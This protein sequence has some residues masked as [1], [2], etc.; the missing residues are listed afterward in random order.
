[1]FL[2][3]IHSPT[4]QKVAMMSWSSDSGTGEELQPELLTPVGHSSMADTYGYWSSLPHAAPS[5]G[6]PYPQ[7]DPSDPNAPPYGT[8]EGLPDPAYTFP[9]TARYP[10]MH[11]PHH[12]PHHHNYPQKAGSGSGAFFSPPG[13]PASN[14]LQHVFTTPQSQQG[15]SSSS[16][17]KIVSRGG[18]GNKYP[19]STF[20]LSTLIVNLSQFKSIYIEY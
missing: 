20:Y 15:S 2:C 6:D 12:H 5:S 10:A 9:T 1:M 16:Y 19:V 4:Q 13:V 7:A 17:E 3:P 11:H 18:Y 14:G 8:Y